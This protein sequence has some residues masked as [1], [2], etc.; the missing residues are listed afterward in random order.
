MLTSKAVLLLAAT[1][2]LG[3][4]DLTTSDG[5]GPGGGTLA[6][7]YS[8][9]KSAIGLPG[10][11]AAAAVTNAGS[12]GLIGARLGP[13]LNEDDRKV[14]YD[15]EIA[16]LDHGAPGAPVPWKNPVSGHYGNIVAGPAYNQKGAQCRGF[17]HTITINGALTSARGTA[18]RSPEGA[19]AAVG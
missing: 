2:A 3:G 5:A 18:C 11:T 15:A 17:S 16:A 10:D 8:S 1:L 7:A 6:R 4:C 14:A 19:W 9:T 12:G 13:L